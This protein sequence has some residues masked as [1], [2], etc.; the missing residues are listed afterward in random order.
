MSKHG[1]LA[2]LPMF[3]NLSASKLFETMPPYRA[4]N[5]VLNYKRYNFWKILRYLTD[6]SNGLLKS[7]TKSVL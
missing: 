2:I 3:S 4:Q 6:L 5:P 1:H 7:L